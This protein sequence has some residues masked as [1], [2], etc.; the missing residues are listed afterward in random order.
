MTGS[1]DSARRFTEFNSGRSIQR[2]RSIPPPQQTSSMK[3]SHAKC[4]AVW[5]GHQ[6]K[7]KCSDIPMGPCHK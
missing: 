3:V 4:G 5:C 2:C 1:L 7:L 6:S